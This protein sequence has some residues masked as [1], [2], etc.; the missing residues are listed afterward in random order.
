MKSSACVLSAALA[1]AVVQTGLA[2][3]EFVLPEHLYAAPGVP[4]CI[5]YSNVFDAVT[6]ERWKFS[7]H[8]EGYLGQAHSWAD[9]WEWTPSRGHA[10]KNL[11]LVLSAWSDDLDY[12]SSATTTLHVASAPAC[13]TNKVTLALFGDSIA[14]CLYGDQLMRTMRKIGFPNY[15]PV[16]SRRL[17][18]DGA[19]MDAFGGWSYNSYLREYMMSKD[20]YSNVQDEAER[21]QLKELKIPVSKLES[22][23][24]DLRRSPLL[25]FRAGKVVVDAKPWLKRVNGGSQPDF[26]FVC[27]GLNATWWYRGSKQDLEAVVWKDLYSRA[28]N[29]LPPFYKAVRAALPDTVI[30]L[31]DAPIGSDQDGFTSNYYSDWNYMQQRKTTFALNKLLMKWV[32]DQNDPKLL[33]APFAYALDPVSGYPRGER[34]ANPYVEEKVNYSSNGVHPSAVGGQQLGD[35]AAAAV[36]YCIGEASK[37]SAKK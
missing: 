19:F 6:P 22:W 7:T 37:K 20:E 17:K 4:C 35:A 27:L 1:A 32:K 28:D 33:F 3:P 12:P 8:Y 13:P 11:K 10:G 25:V 24:G 23:Q 14:N 31:A 30:L 36:A 34:K 26:L 5:Y 21:A 18:D 2:K 15:T 16:G 29:E 9:H